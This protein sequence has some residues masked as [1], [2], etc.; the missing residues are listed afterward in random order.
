MTNNNTKKSLAIAAM[1][2]F[3]LFAFSRLAVAQSTF[4]G[5][6][7]TDYDPYLIYNTDQLDQLADDVNNGNT[8]ENVW[9][10][11]MDDLDYTNKTYTPIGCVY[12]D[13][14]VTV[15]R[16]FCGGFWGNNH[17]INNVTINSQDSH[18]GLFGFV[19]YGGIIYELTLGGNS[20]IV[21]IGFAGGI[22]GEVWSDANI[23]N[24][25]VGENVLISVHPVASGSAYAPGDL[26]GIAGYSS[27]IILDCVSKAT[28]NNGGI[29]KTENLGGIV[30]GLGSAGRVE[31]CR[32]LGTVIGTRHV[33]DVVGYSNGTITYNYYHTSVRHGGVDGNDTDGAKW[34]GTVTFGEQVSGSLL[35]AT[36]WDG[37]TPYFGVGKAM[38]MENMSYNAQRALLPRA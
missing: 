19:G 4:G 8:Y 23:I 28:I 26:G 37:G 7:G 22:A 13:G 11:L 30:G 6:S 32:F 2:I 9:F 14:T 35:E 12:F 21:S 25:H 10:K 5:G 34:M 31:Y 36:F 3:N 16:R 1:L 29:A 24:C 38:W 18:C 20:S 17:S 27:G 15:E 33:G